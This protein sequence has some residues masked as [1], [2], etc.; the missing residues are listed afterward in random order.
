MVLALSFLVTGTSWRVSALM[1]RIPQPTDTVVSESGIGME[2][3]HD[4]T[5]TSFLE[6]TVSGE[7]SGRFQVRGTEAVGYTVI[8]KDTEA[9][10]G[11]LGTSSRKIFLLLNFSKDQAH[12]DVRQILLPRCLS[13]RRDA[14]TLASCQRGAPTSAPDWPLPAMNLFILRF[15]P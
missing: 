3:G 14:P 15:S 9:A 7:E 11:A 10:V 6:E 5:T 12:P 1:P 13:S 8:L 4:G 2:L